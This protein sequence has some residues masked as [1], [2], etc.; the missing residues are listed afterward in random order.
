M[1]CRANQLG[2]GPVLAGQGSVRPLDRES[3][4]GP[5]LGRSRERGAH[6]HC[7]G[8]SRAW[9]RSR[10]GGGGFVECLL[11]ASTVVRASSP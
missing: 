9:S 7:G 5:S 8:G 1:G 11:W 3:T 6:N 2:L 4:L 10:G